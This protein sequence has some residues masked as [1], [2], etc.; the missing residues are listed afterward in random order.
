[1]PLTVG[2]YRARLLDERVAFCFHRD[3]GQDGARCVLHDSGDVLCAPAIAGSA[4]TQTNVRANDTAILLNMPP[5]LID[6]PTGLCRR[7]ATA[8]PDK[9]PWKI[10][11]ADILVRSITNGRIRRLFETP[12]L[13]PFSAAPIEAPSGIRIRSAGVEKADLSDT[14]RGRW[15]N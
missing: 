3:T 9:N 12:A 15:R 8:G 6:P 13:Y 1:L 14:A 2:D 11:I 7:E 10:A 4:A 5:L